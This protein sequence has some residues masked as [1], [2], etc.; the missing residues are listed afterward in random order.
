MAGKYLLGARER[1]H[2]RKQ[3]GERLLLLG[4]VVGGDAAP[5]ASRLRHQRGQLLKHGSHVAHT[6]ARPLGNSAN[7]AASRFVA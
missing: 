2:Q 5:L 1:L 4:V 6:E 3:D 7:P